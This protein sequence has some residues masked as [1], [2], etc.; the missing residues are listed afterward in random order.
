MRAAARI[1]EWEHRELTRKVQDLEQK[2]EKKKQKIQ[3]LKEKVSTLKQENKRVRSSLV[4]EEKAHEKLK[5][6]ME[7]RR[8]GLTD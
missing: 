2:L 7:G 5:G 3:H 8:F 6:I 1:D 4:E